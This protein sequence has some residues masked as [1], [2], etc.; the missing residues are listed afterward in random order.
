MGATHRAAA[1]TADRSE[2]FE[3]NTTEGKL[4]QV[5]K[6]GFGSSGRT[7]DAARSRG[8]TNA[9]PVAPACAQQGTAAR[10]V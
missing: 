2:L 5:S 1:S 9:T 3:G 8:H 6:L 10:R 4:Q 7:M